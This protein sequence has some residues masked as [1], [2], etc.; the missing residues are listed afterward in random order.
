[1]IFDPE[2]AA[3]ARRHA[4]AQA[5][6]NK[7]TSDSQHAQPQASPDKANSISAS[8]RTPEGSPAAVAA[9]SAA[10]AAVAS[11]AGGP[12]ENNVETHGATIASGIVTSDRFSSATGSA[13]GADGTGGGYGRKS[14]AASGDMDG[15]E[16]VGPL[17]PRQ[18][19][20]MKQR[21]L[22]KI[23]VLGSSNVSLFKMMLYQ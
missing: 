13:S 8:E 6:L 11:S 10:G 19:G 7:A 18:R 21:V 14:S 15:V 2:L 1:M 22:L 5:K 16:R 3:A 12:P 17:G 9:N 23:I 20:S 4:R